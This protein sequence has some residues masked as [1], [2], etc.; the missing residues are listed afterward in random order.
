MAA[1]WLSVRWWA[2]VRQQP[3]PGISYKTKQV[4]APTC[5]CSPV[6]MISYQI[7][8]ACLFPEVLGFKKQIALPGPHKPVP[9]ETCCLL[10]LVPLPL[11]ER[12][13]HPG[14]PRAALVTGW[15]WPGQPRRFCTIRA[16]GAVTGEVVSSQS[17]TEDGVS[18]GS[19]RS[20]SVCVWP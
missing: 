14:G 4:L 18:R 10:S 11:R 20:C 16:R 8:D 7:G 17:L 15:R 1:G 12:Q 3:L 2:G 19:R 13:A 5:F 6:K 9:S